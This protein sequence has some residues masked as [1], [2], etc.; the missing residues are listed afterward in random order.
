MKDLLKLYSFES[1][2][3]SDDET[4][5]ADWICKWLDA[6]DVKDYTR[7]GNNI[8]YFN[9]EYDGLILS[10]HLDQ[11]RTNGKAVHFYLTPE[12]YIVAYNKDWQ[13][14][15]LGAD[16]KNGVWLILKAIEEGLKPSFIISEGEEAGLI[17][18]NHL[19]YNKVLDALNPEENY[20]IVLDRKGD[21]DVLNQGGG[22]TFCNT[23]A[24]NIINFLRDPLMVK[25]T[26]SISDTTEI[27]S[28]CEAVNMSVAYFNPHTAN[29]YTDWG[30]L[31][32]IKNNLF[33]I[34][35]NFVHYPSLPETYMKKSYYQASKKSTTTYDSN[36]WNDNQ[37]RYYDDWY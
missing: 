37:G 29:E 34:L 28:Y 27:C 18:I 19:S 33:D 36:Y 12:E 2:H 25:T 13:R 21:G 5:I 23:L 35:T 10:A 3:N 9:F 22:T 14:T 11:V 7:D 1:I 8:Y 4:A 31:E 6:H 30:R 20:C 16:D 26:G 24:D 17:G 32:E 15:S